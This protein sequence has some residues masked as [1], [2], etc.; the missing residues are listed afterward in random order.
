[1][2]IVSFAFLALL[3]ALAHAN[4]LAA[5]GP[6]PAAGTQVAQSSPQ[7][8]GSDDA[9]LCGD[10]PALADKE[11]AEVLGSAARADADAYADR[12]SELAA[13]SE[14]TVKRL[15]QTS[16]IAND[17]IKRHYYLAV[18]QRLKEKGVAADSL[19][20]A[21]LSVAQVLDLAG[22]ATAAATPSQQVAAAEPPATSA[23]P[24]APEAAP[25][26][27]EPT[28]PN[29][30]TDIQPPS[31][32]AEGAA[33]AGTPRAESAQQPAPDTT[34]EQA[35]AGVAQDPAATEQ[36]AEAAP[37]V[38]PAQPSVPAPEP[39]ALDNTPAA[40]QPAEPSPNQNAV[41]GAPP[42]GE[43][44]AD[45][46]AAPHTSTMAQ[47]DAPAGPPQGAI[48]PGPVP[49]PMQS[50]PGSVEQ[51]AASAPPADAAASAP[52]PASA[53]PE[54]PAQTAEAPVTP[55]APQD[56]QGAEQP[57][58]PHSSTMA[59]GDAP[60]GQPKGAI[61]P[62]AVP[63]PMQSSPGSVEQPS[64]SE[65]P[66]AADA[67]PAAPAPAAPAP[68]AQA[69]AAPAASSAS[70]PQTPAPGA[71]PPPAPVPLPPPTE[72]T[73]PKPAPAPGGIAQLGEEECRA[74]GVLTACP[75][76]NT[77]L[78]RLLERPLEYNRPTV[79]YQYRKS[80]I[81]LVLRTD[82]QGKDLPPEVS[83]QMRNMPGEVQQGITKITRV[84]SAE[85][86][87]RDFEIAPTGRQE[88]TVV[89]P[90]PVT[91]TW[92]VQPTASGPDKPLKLQLYAHIEGPNGTMPP[93]LIKT[94]DATI[95]VDVRTW[96]WVL[97]QVRELEPLYAVVAALLG[98]LT[99]VL[100]YYFTRP[101]E[102]PSGGRSRG[103]GP[104]IGDLDQ[105]S[106]AGLPPRPRNDDP[107][108][109]RDAADDTDPRAP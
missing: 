97:A 66:R 59:Q 37:P 65:T 1:M 12:L 62:G 22:T 88:R 86:S 63:E 7:P 21:L 49:E 98:L 13:K 102:T 80:E 96:D 105:S 46:P 103:G 91:W 25:T 108:R 99:A 101:S 90:Q 107:Y 106:G 83:E 34:I 43:P 94:L 50:S 75:D 87:G 51:P 74:L 89:I 61:T 31:T 58:A 11:S 76:L 6:A 42:P 77:V 32:L 14:E 41:Q 81:G 93:I 64:T 26:A 16:S 92:Q 71:V 8:A 45:Q 4:G 109:E 67:A 38:T 95:N 82:W 23:E 24:K 72:A 57:A 20:P 56:R 52:P 28:S 36:K 10:A 9:V 19:R 40:P 104:V 17:T 60:A 85:L 68:T 54:P 70:P 73:A 5:Q 84:M 48:T 55:P 53:A 39:A 47:G 15:T 30:P 29:A 2:R 27:P 79:L 44:G 35:P 18:C 78:A 3:P 100:T 69:P 33:P